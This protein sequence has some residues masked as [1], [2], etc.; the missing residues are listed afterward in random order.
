MQ[1]QLEY[2]AL[3]CAAVWPLLLQHL[4]STE[5][6]AVAPVVL[7]TPRGGE[8]RPPQALVSAGVR[9]RGAARDFPP[10]PPASLSFLLWTVEEMAS[11]HSNT[12]T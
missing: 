9:V 3:V 6:E 10:A 4:H 7:W 5:L 1:P 2:K 11:T 12:D 8:A